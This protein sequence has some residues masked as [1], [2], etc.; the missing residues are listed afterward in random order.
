MQTTTDVI[1]DA[2]LVPE[3]LDA[4]EQ[5][6][7]RE[8]DDG[9]LPSCQFAIAKDGKVV[10]HRTLGD[11]TDATR[12]CIFSST[13]AFAASAFWMLLG[14]G[15][16]STSDRVADLLPNFGE[17]DKQDV[18]V[19][20]V[21]LHTAGFPNGIMGPR[22]WGSHAGRLEVYP[23]WKL[24]WEPGTRY[25]YHAMSAHWVLMDILTELTGTDYRDFIRERICEPIGL[26]S[27]RLGIP[28]AEQTDLADVSYVGEAMTPEEME[29]AFGFRSVPTPRGSLAAMGDFGLSLNEPEWR[30]IGIP[31]GGGFSNAADV[32]RFYQE[33]LH[34]SKGLWD[35]D[36]LADGTQRVR[37]NLPDP[38]YRVP[39]G[40]ALGTVVAGDDGKAHMRGF[41]RTFSARAFGHGGAGGQVA[42]ADPE[43]GISFCYLTNGHDRHQL[44]QG[45]RGVALASLAG[46]LTTPAD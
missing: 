24:D 38:L 28:G 35:P 45:R 13:K 12:Y 21:L 37:N 40:R 5:R 30:E 39:A 41:G 4:L 17:N 22:H 1:V 42:I 2:G 11:A 20:H 6:V 27:F 25:A 36:V 7:R 31:G 18:T 33:L 16:V 19:E 8:I 43:T 29:A 14:E 26:A 32:T 44:R 10:V 46:L 3:R 9:L 34:N 15:L 23:H